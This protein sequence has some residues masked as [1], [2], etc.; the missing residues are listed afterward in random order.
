M[1]NYDGS[2]PE[3]TSGDRVHNALRSR[4]RSDVLGHL[5]AAPPQL[6]NALGVVLAVSA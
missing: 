2:R 3:L 6:A 4:M 1:S 5:T